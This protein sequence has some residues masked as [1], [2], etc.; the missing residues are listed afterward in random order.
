VDYEV[1]TCDSGALGFQTPEANSVMGFSPSW[2]GAG[3]L[4]LACLECI[5]EL[6]IRCSDAGSPWPQPGKGG[7]I[8]ILKCRFFI[9]FNSFWVIEYWE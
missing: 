8:I 4:L 9:V 1:D 6:R 7:T 3:G 5:V 2:V